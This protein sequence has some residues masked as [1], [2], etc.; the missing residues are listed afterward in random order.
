MNIKQLRVRAGYTQEKLANL[1][2]IDRSAIAHWENG[3]SIPRAKML[4]KLALLLK[5]STDDL[6]G[7]AN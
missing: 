1:L 2:Q 3:D 7:I 4:P 5:C 6:L